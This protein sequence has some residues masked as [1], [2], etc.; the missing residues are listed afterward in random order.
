[1]ILT[2]HSPFIVT[3]FSP[4]SIIR[5][6]KDKHSETKVASDG[7]T[8]AIED[9][10][11]GLGYRMSVLPAET[12]FADYVILVEGPSEEM[13]YRTLASQMKIDLDRLNISVLCVNGVDFVT[14]I[15]ILEAMEIRWSVRTDNDEI[16]VATVVE[17]LKYFLCSSLFPSLASLHALGNITVPITEQMVIGTIIILYE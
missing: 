4:N 8:K 12:F 7:C 15:K 5:L 1:M 11:E 16:A 3:E 17:Y 14:Y 2:S 13:L 6:Y 10:F 9:G